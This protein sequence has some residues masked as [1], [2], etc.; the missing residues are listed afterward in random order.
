MGQTYRLVGSQDPSSRIERV[1]VEEPSAEHS[2]GVVLELGGEPVELTDEQVM[3]VAGYARLERT[4]LEEGE[5]VAVFGPEDYPDEPQ[6]GEQS[7]EDP[8]K[9]EDKSSANVVESIT[10]PA[11]PA[12]STNV[13]GS[14]G[15]KEA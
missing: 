5:E 2:E 10:A 13:S 3:K 9:G 15:R 7:A 4:D 12:E 8:Q 6:D 11:T 1:I 14:R